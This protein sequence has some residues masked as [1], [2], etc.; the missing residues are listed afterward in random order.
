MLVVLALSGAARAQETSVAL[1]LSCAGTDVDV[2]KTGSTTTVKTTP[3]VDPGIG[4]AEHRAAVIA[5]STR[6]ETTTTPVYSDVRVPA[7][8]SVAIQGDTIRVRPSDN[9]RPG[10]GAKRSPD[11]WYDLAEVAIT[12]TQFRGKAAYGGILSGKYRLTIDRQTGDAQFGSFRGV[13]DKA[14]TGPTERRF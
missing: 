5:G 8:L 2:Q 9:T 6:T 1:M 14:A 11:G 12:E 4:S 13:C 3:G 10:L 7:R